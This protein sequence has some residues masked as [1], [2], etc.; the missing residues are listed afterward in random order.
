MIRAFITGIGTDV[1]KTVVS[2]IIAKKYNAN[3]W[4]PIQCGNLD[5]SDSKRVKQLSPKTNVFGEIYRFKNGLS[6]HAAANREGVSI[7]LSKIAIPA[8]KES[9][10]V[11]GAGGILVPLNNQETNLDLIKWLGLPVIVVSRHYLGSINHTLLSLSVLK[12]AGISVMGIIFIGKKNPESES[13]I[14]RFGRIGMISRIPEARNVDA[15][16]ISAQAKK[17]FI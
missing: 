9:I 13:I 12:H 8:G 14:L 7:K 10:V 4:K 15:N 1:G 17:V 6:P 2:A 3:Y 16:F 5:S 11:E